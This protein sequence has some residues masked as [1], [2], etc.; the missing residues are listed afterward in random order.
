MI[1]QRCELASHQQSGVLDLV[2]PEHSAQ[3]RKR[4]RMRSIVHFHRAVKDPAIKISGRL[5][6]RSAVQRD[7]GSHR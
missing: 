6:V 4:Y 7:V 5:E 3:D 2:E 1:Q